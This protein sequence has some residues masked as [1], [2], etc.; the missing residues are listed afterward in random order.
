MKA[1]CKQLLPW[2]PS[3]PGPNPALVAVYVVA[4]DPALTLHLTMLKV[5][6][7][8][9]LLNLTPNV[10]WSNTSPAPEGS[11]G[12]PSSWGETKQWHFTTHSSAVKLKEKHGRRQIVQPHACV[13]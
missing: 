6:T 13:H 12:P 10:C 8:S 7:G 3:I 5:T 4:Q 2:E 11:S 1:A 9:S